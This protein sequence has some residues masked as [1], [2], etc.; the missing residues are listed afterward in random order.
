MEES[1]EESKQAQGHSQSLQSSGVSYHPMRMQEIKQPRDL[2]T[3]IEMS[4]EG[5]SCPVTPSL[6]N[7]TPV[8]S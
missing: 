1:K 5:V 6:T 4:E 3:I 8:A 2:D 7:Q